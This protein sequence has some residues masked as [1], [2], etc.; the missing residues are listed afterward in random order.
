[1]VL[2]NS[3]QYAWAG[4][5][6]P[7]AVASRATLLDLLRYV[8]SFDIILVPV[9]RGPWSLLLMAAAAGRRF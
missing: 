3:E 1:M 5:H 4:L 7:L 9:E 2:S 6:V 8:V